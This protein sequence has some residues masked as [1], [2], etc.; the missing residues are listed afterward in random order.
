MSEGKSKH[1]TTSTTAGQFL[2]YF[3]AEDDAKFF[4]SL[5]LNCIRIPVSSQYQSKNGY[6]QLSVIAG[7]LPPL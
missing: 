1:I 3:F 5:G 4:A 6:L 7:K 2:E